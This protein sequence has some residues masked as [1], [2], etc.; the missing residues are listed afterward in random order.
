MKK[1]LGILCPLLLLIA[2]RAHAQTPAPAT[3]PNLVLNGAAA[4]AGPDGAPAHWSLNLRKGN[5]ALSRVKEAE[6][7]GG[8]AARL[9]LRGPDTNYTLAIGQ[10]QV[11][12]QTTDAV[13][14][15]TARA[16]SE[17]PQGAKAS[18]YFCVGASD[19]LKVIN[20]PHNAGWQDVRAL[21]T[22]PA[23]KDFGRL[24]F[25]GGGGPAVFFIASARVQALSAEDAKAE[26]ARDRA[27]RYSP[28]TAIPL[29]PGQPLTVKK[30][31]PTDCRLVRGFTHAPFDGR[32]DTR[33]AKGGVG[34]WLCVYGL[35]AV[36]YRLFNGNNGLHVTLPQEPFNAI[37]VRGEWTGR[38]YADCHSLL[39]PDKTVKPLSHI[40]PKSGVFRC[41][42]DA[43]V[44]ASRLSFFYDEPEGKPLADVSF[45]RVTPGQPAQTG[46]AIYGLGPAATPDALIQDAIKARFQ[47][48]QNI[49]QLQESP[50][51]EISLKQDE[52]LHMLTPPQDPALGLAAVSASL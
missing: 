33:H 34:E 9:E 40:L 11:P 29:H 6:A 7:Q 52:W 4:E 14:V 27:E 2:L 17:I 21:V 39:P 22:V 44:R 12:R 10:V 38:L 47:G 15:F 31:M 43:P 16:K 41:S 51:G 3:P 45:L 46:M 28:R 24:D 36:N 49:R 5:A 48:A 37:L 25:Q 26:A 23:G 32:A 19:D 8:A 18:G 35:P 20:F 30:I 13:Y 42:F 50:G 1:P